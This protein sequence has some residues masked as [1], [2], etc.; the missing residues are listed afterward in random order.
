MGTATPSTL[1]IE[2]P[3]AT[4]ALTTSALLSEHSCFDRYVCGVRLSEQQSKLAT[5]RL[6]L[7]N[8]ASQLTARRQ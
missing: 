4:V 1:P 6:E 8:E 5:S 3:D 7:P 2:R